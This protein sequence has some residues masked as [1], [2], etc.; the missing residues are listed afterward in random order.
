MV[1]ETLSSPDMMTATAAEFVSFF[2]RLV[3]AVVFVAVG[4]FVGSILS[5]VVK[6][7]FDAVQLEEFL[8]NHKVEDALGSTKVDSVLVQIVKYY[9][10]ILFIADAMKIVQLGTV[11]TLMGNI[12]MFAPVAFAGVLVV[13]LAAVF[14]ELLKEKVLEVSSK[15]TLAQYTSK[16]VKAIVIYVGIVIALG[17]MGFEVTILEQIFTTILQ[18]IGYAIALAFGLAF[19][20][21]GQDDAKDIL[22][23]TRK[24]FSV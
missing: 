9:V 24:K 12:V 21:G 22:K 19:G 18:S 17:T 15:S 14:G 20:F 3:L 23:K 4:W 7:V 6:R 16:G 2:L 13:V 5:R 11:G 8:K 10:V 1:L